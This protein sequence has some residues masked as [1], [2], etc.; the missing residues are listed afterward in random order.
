MIYNNVYVRQVAL[1]NFKNKDIRRLLELPSLYFICKYT[2]SIWSFR[3]R[4]TKIQKKLGG[5]QQK[6][7]E[8]QS[9]ENQFLTHSVTFTERFVPHDLDWGSCSICLLKYIHFKRCCINNDGYRIVKWTDAFETTFISIRIKQ[10]QPYK[11][12]ITKI[13]TNA[14]TALR[15][16]STFIFKSTY[17]NLNYREYILCPSSH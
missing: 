4:S 3:A 8:F 10:N 13:L 11:S 14:K 12:T 15:I 1:G 16:K 9:N 17:R 7:S 5:P 2:Y 6:H